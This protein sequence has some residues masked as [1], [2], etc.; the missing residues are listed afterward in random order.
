MIEDWYSPWDIQFYRAQLIWLFYYLPEIKAG[1][2]PPGPE[3]IKSGQMSFHAPFEMRV[4]ITVEVEERVKMA[5]PDGY[6]CQDYFTDNIFDGHILANKY[7]CPVSE[8]RMRIFRAL[9]Y[10]AGKARKRISY[11]DWI[12]LGYA[13][14]RKRQPRKANIPIEQRRELRKAGT[15]RWL[16]EMKREKSPA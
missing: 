16:K 4:L 5:G 9:R 6:M 13:Q 3:E 8:V 10:M 7:N 12:K 2:W 15:A 11:A 14:R 1:R